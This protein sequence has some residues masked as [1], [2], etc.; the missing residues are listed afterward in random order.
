LMMLITV[1]MAMVLSS[2]RVTQAANAGDV[3]EDAEAALKKLYA[4]EPA[5]KVL[6]EKVKAILVFPNIVK[7]G[8]MVSAQYGE[9][10]L[11]QN[12]QVAGHYNTVAGSYGFQAGAQAFG[13][14]MF[15]MTDKAIEYLDKSSGWEVGV[16]PSIVVVKKGMG[17][18]LT[19][20]TLKDDVYAFIFNQKGLMGGAGIQGSKIT[21]IK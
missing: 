13:Y 18:S 12:G 20:T 4:S 3:D 11:L 6:G 17:K 2:P 15:L 10:V 8:F 19:T 7:G 9:G 5:A 14:A 1:S 16:G 21:K